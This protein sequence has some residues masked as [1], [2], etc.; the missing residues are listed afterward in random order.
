[1]MDANGREIVSPLDMTREQIDGA[2]KP[3]RIE[4]IQDIGWY[5]MRFD[6]SDARPHM[7]QVWLAMGQFLVIDDGEFRTRDMRGWAIRVHEPT[8]TDWPNK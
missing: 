5:W 2:V 7:H 6:G 3:V 4:S 1:M 8:L